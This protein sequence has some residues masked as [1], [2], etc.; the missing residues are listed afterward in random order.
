MANLLL[1]GCAQPNLPAAP[2]STTTVTRGCNCNT[3]AGHSGVTGPS[4]AAA[5]AAAL[6]EPVAI[7]TRCRAELIVP[8][9]CV[10]TRCGT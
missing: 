3:D 6:C 1:D 5:T 8:N 4:N 9:P 10:M 2:S 7:N